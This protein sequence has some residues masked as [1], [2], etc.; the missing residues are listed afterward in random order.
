MFNEIIRFMMAKS[1]GR[2][3]VKMAAKNSSNE[4]ILKEKLGASSV[5]EFMKI[6]IND[7]QKLK[8]S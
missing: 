1:I 6:N 7:Y 2:D 8:G 3:V 5:D 4:D